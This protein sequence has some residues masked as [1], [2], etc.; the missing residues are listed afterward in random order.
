[1]KIKNM[2]MLALGS[3]LI[4]TGCSESEKPHPPEAVEPPRM[5]QQPA[6]PQAELLAQP[7]L[8]PGKWD[9]QAP[10]NLQPLEAALRRKEPGTLVY[11]LYTWAG[12]YLTFRDDI[13]KVGWPSI[14]IAGPFHDSIMTALAEDEATTMV[15]VGNWLLD[16]VR[17]ANRT[18]YESDESLIEDYTEKLDAFVSKYGK[19]GTFLREH[20]ELPQ[21]P[22][23]DIE[24]WNEPNFQYLIPPD[25]SPWQ[26]METKREKLYA[27][28]LPALYAATKAKHPEANIVGFAAGGMSAGDLRFIQHVH[29]LNPA[30]AKSYDVLS[31]HPYVRPAAPE[32]NSVQP[33][34]S[35]SISRNLNMIRDTLGKHGRA[36]APVWYTEIGWPILPEDGG[37]FPAAKPRECIPPLFQA[38]YVC[39]TYALALRLNVE[40]VHIMYITD[41][42]HF[43]AGFF[44]KDTKAWRPSATAVQTMIKTMPN[45]KLTGSISDGAD[46]CYAYTCQADS[47]QGDVPGNKVIMAWNVGGP[48]TLE[49]HDLPQQVVITDML[50]T[51]QTRTTN[52]GTLSVEIGPF[53]IYLKGKMK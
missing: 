13:Q 11:G 37:H 34:G 47:A 32:A 16:P 53:P 33:W 19:E 48:K 12:E 4:A 24:L 29:E 41:A 25:G 9:L 3:A 15:T 40:R 8:V 26:E 50:G 18:G 31:T 30:V 17:N 20:P 39:R 27:K 2:T 42:D 38:A 22:I 1:M 44:D 43:N 7:G 46:G 36:D 5:E 28:I 6:A 52:E 10:Q 35:Y 51:T 23:I 49:L 14:R 45:P 21:R